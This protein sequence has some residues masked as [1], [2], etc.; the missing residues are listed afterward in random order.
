MYN[1]FNIQLNKLRTWLIPAMLQ[2]DVLMAFTEAIYTPIVALHNSFIAFRKSKFYEIKMNYQTCYLQAFLN[3]RFDSIQRRIYIVDAVSRE[4][5]YIYT[6]AEAKALVISKRS[7]A[8][9]VAV[10]TR[11]ESNG[12][13]LHDFYVFV[14]A[15][16]G[17]DEHEMRA[18]IATKLCGKRYKIQLF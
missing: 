12:D 2:T 1:I 6:R 10:Y 8:Q 3:D 17:F 5:V 4:P 9:S 7:E 16:V 13:L 14:P 11:G 18:M 15:N